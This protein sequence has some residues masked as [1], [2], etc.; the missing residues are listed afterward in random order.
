MSL[1]SAQS[2]CW[3]WQRKC[4]EQSKS[5]EI[6]KGVVSLLHCHVLVAKY[7][8]CAQCRLRSSP[9]WRA[10]S[11]VRVRRLRFLKIPGRGHKWEGG[12]SSEPASEWLCSLCLEVLAS[13]Q[14]ALC[15]D[16]QVETYLWGLCVEGKLPSCQ[17]FQ[18]KMPLKAPH[19]TNHDSQ[20]VET[21]K[22]PPTDKG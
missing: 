16:F 17:P 4:K 22:C 12:R 2:F 10:Y 14:M 5:W 8:L 6:S 11:L 15:P 3:R 18:I 1:S 9:F 19:S 21:T 13:V 20:R 7:L